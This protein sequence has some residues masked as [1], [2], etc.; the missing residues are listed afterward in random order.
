MLNF[1]AFPFPKNAA[2]P[3]V[4]YFQKIKYILKDDKTKFKCEYYGSKNRLS[5]Y[6]ANNYCNNL[7]KAN[8]RWRLPTIYELI[9]L[10]TGELL[11][12]IKILWAYVRD[13]VKVIYR[14]HKDIKKAFGRDIWDFS[15]WSNTIADKKNLSHWIM[16]FGDGGTYFEKDE[17]K[18]YAICIAIM[19]NDNDR[20]E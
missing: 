8:F 7:I 9:S 2:N 18:H 17:K 16:G 5:F 4:L 1:F 10:Y 20:K 6:E 13:Y 14:F 15:V 12:D 11:K 3:C 19:E